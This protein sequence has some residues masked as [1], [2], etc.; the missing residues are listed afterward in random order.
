MSRLKQH[1]GREVKVY[2]I[3]EYGKTYSRLF[4]R[5]TGTGNEKFKGIY[6]GTLVPFYGMIDDG[7]K[8]LIKAIMIRD[9]VHN[10]RKIFTW[11]VDLLQYL[12]EKTDSAMLGDMQTL[13]DKYFNTPGEILISIK[14]R[15]GFWKNNT[16][17][18]NEIIK[19]FK[20]NEY[21]INEIQDFDINNDTNELHNI[22]NDKKKLS[23]NWHESILIVVQ[24]EQE[25]RINEKIA[26]RKNKAKSKAKNK[27]KSK[28]KS[29]AKKGG[30]K[31]KRKAN[32]SLKRK[33]IKNSKMLRSIIY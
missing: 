1:F 29:K 19:F 13:L 15:N 7:N 6:A 8:T 17:I 24:K 33:K 26:S 22:E 30:E 16:N 27:A 9:K 11:Q 14:D 12:S 20:Q 23:K 10:D 4:Y 2:E 5:S 32:K 18:A 3:E 25:E 21:E 31:T 28:A